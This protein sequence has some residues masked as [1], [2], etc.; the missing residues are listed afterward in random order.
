LTVFAAAGLNS[1]ILIELLLGSLGI[2][3]LSTLVTLQM[4]KRRFRE[5][6]S[7]EHGAPSNH[8]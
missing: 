3:L 6:W 5:L 7:E 8:Q 2:V 1:V 4:V